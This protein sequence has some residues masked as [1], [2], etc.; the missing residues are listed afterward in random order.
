MTI[1]NADDAKLFHRANQEE[2]RTNTRIANLTAKI[3][4]RTQRDSGSMITIAA[5]TMFFLPGTFV[6]VRRLIPSHF[7]FRKCCRPL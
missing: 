4:Q 3:A 2:N 5:V 7:S 1:G 6:S